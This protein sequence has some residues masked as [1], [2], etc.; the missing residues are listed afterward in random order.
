M[1]VWNGGIKATFNGFMSMMPVGVLTAIVIL[2][3]PSVGMIAFPEHRKSSSV[4]KVYK[5]FTLV[6]NMTAYC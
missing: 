3:N 4:A 6:A 2:P 1:L 5:P